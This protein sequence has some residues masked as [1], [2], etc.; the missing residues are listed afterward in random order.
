MNTKEFATE[1]RTHREAKNVTLADL[2]SLTKIHPRYL[3]A[4]EE[5]DF[6]FL[7]A[8]YVRAFLRDYAKALELD[9]DDIIRRY[10]TALEASA[11]TAEAQDLKHKAPSF[12]F[13]AEEKRPSPR[14]G[15]IRSL[16]LSFR[17]LVTRGDKGQ[18]FLPITAVIFVLLIIVLVAN[19]TR[20][21]RR[22]ETPEIPFEQVIREK[23][24]ARSTQP[25]IAQQEGLGTS[26]VAVHGDSLLL[27]GRTTH[28]VWIRIYIDNQPP[29]DY[30]L[31]PN[32]V[33]S[34]KAKERFRVSLGNAGGIIFTL[35]GKEL[36]TLGKLGAVVQTVPITRDGAQR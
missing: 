24:D 33:R 1:L 28:D 32:E 34:W 11:Q 17:D 36:G 22:S 27:E 3:R 31:G 16:W 29:R 26:P 14:T 6:S 20:S 18:K 15:I 19:L 21:P 8:P 35:N 10:E 30:L 5:G 4:M 2:S 12:H 9:P 7:P 13:P 23:E 25:D